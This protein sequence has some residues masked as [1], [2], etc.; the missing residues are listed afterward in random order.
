MYAKKQV[1]IKERPY[2]HYPLLSTVRRDIPHLLT[3]GS[4][5]APWM[6]WEETLIDMFVPRF[7]QVK[8]TNPV[9]LMHD[10]HTIYLESRHSRRVCIQSQTIYAQMEGTYW[11]TDSTAFYQKGP[12]HR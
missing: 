1:H 7:L 4:T 3:V 12:Q 8:L 11:V 2:Q 5:L 10:P 9:L 6:A